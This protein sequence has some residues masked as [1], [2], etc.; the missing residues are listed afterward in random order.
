MKQTIF[1]VYVVGGSI[2][3]VAPAL[4]S[5]TQNVNTQ[6]AIPNAVSTTILAANAN[7]RRAVIQNLSGVTI[8]LAFGAA[9]AAT[10]IALPTGQSW[11]VDVGND[12]YEQRGDINAF[13]TSGAP[14]NVNVLEMV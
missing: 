3:I 9:A 11:L 2:S 6:V 14:V 10:S 5:I 7:R 13:Q 4:T 8:F 12:W 1:R